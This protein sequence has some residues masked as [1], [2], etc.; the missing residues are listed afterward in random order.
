MLKFSNLKFMG[1]FLEF[2]GKHELYN[3][4]PS[5]SMLLMAQYLCKISCIN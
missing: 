5:G 2:E 4:N 3:G 1:L